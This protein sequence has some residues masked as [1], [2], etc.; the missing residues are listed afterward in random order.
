MLIGVISKPSIGF[1]VKA[2]QNVQPQEYIKYFED[3]TF[4]SNA[5]FESKWRF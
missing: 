4:C 5:G 1:K 3:W 2:K